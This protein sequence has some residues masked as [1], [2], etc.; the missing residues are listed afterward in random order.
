MFF[1]NLTRLL[2]IQKYLLKHDARNFSRIS[3][4]ILEKPVGKSTKVQGWV[5]ALRKMK[6]NIFCDVYDGST[7]EMLQVVIPKSSK[8][9][10]LTYGS[11]IDVEGVLALAP[12]G[13]L[14]LQVNEAYVIGTCDVSQ[15]YPLTPKKPYDAEFLRQYLHFRP[16]TQEFSSLLRLRDVATASINNYFR[17]RNFIHIHTPII[18]SNDCEGAGEIFTVKPDSKEVLESMKKDGMSLDEI[19]FN[20]K[21]YLTVS[22]QLQL[23]VLA[24]TLSKVYTF[25]PTFRAENS[26]SRLHLSEFYM[27]EAERAFVS[28]IEE[29]TEE[30][31]LLMKTVTKD[32]FDRNPSDFHYIGAVEPQWLNCKFGYM[33]YDEAV[34][35]LNDHVVQL[36][37]PI[38][39][40]EGL[41][42]EHE[43]FLVKHNNNVPIF[44]INWPKEGKP[45]YMKECSNDSSKVAGLDLLVPIVGE[46]VGGSIRED[47]YEKLKLKLPSNHN[48]SWYLEIR[49]YG[50]VPTGGFGMGFERFLQCVLGITNIKDTIPFPRWPHNCSL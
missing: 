48:L 27:I 3:D 10:N 36:Q 33:T 1:R 28:N 12:N 15:G 32:M 49:K 23:E 39:Y 25:G 8:P 30:V 35:I 18:T 44:V 9:N 26:K 20:S 40:G 2:F 38:K 47:D 14:E 41:S 16:R 7:N 4:L 31:E 6:N 5:Y 45:F 17:N 19:Y 46:L 37:H 29:I 11:S 34:N 21:A 43:L 22:G 42:K 50:N 13:R 24:R